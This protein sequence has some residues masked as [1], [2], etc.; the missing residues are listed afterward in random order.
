MNRRSVLSEVLRLVLSVATVAVMAM[1]SAYAET[2]QRTVHDMT[3]AAV[4]VP[5]APRRI[6]DLWFAHNEVLA[7]LGAA[8]RIVVTVDRPQQQPWLFYLVPELAKARHVSPGG[9]DPESLLADRVDLA[10]VSSGLTQASGLRQAS[11]PVLDM[12]FQDVGG[13]LRSLTLTADALN[14]PIARERAARYRR[15]LDEELARIEKIIGNVS[16]DRKPR[17]LH[18]TSI[19]PLQVDGAHTIVDQWIHS[20]G[21]RNAAASVSG[22]KR[23]V[24]AEQIAAWDPDIIIVQGGVALPGHDANGDVPTGW[25]SFRAVKSGHV[26]ANPVGMFP[27][28][29]Y[30]TE[31]LLQVR[32]AAGVLH[33]DLFASSDLKDAMKRFYHD[34]I[35]RD[36]S[37]ADLDRM[38]SGRGPV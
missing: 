3:G 13:L 10:F 26:F 37:D 34:Y 16:E 9:I 27:W 6:A 2:E 32:W 19:A 14:D 33:P 22:V 24:T 31:F 25:D 30:G 5:V 4:A 38:L 21:G 28:D 17:V 1:P 36:L 18:L 11:L 29:R 15:E 8:D 7:M 20:A 35:S 23:P 12:T